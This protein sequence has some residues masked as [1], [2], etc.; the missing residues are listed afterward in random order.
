MSHPNPLI[1]PGARWANLPRSARIGLG[2]GLLALAAIALAM[3]AHETL[4]AGP[5]AE[6]V[7]NATLNLVPLLAAAVG[8]YLAPVRKMASGMTSGLM[9]LL[10]SLVVALL[11]LGWIAPLI[12][13]VL[14]VSLVMVSIQVA[15][16]AALGSVF[17]RLVVAWQ[18][19]SRLSNH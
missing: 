6:L 19:R 14:L 4:N 8:A 7:V 1:S 10:P 17:S 13:P 12:L 2:F 15:I 11:A 16:G 9:S 18:A 5:T 3:S